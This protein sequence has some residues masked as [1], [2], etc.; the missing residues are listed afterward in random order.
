MNVFGSCP[1]LR[2]DVVQ[3]VTFFLAHVNNGVSP[4]PQMHLREA[5]LNM[6]SQLRASTGERLYMVLSDALQEDQ[7]G[8]EAFEQLEDLLLNTPWAS[9][10]HADE[11]Q[12]VFELL[13][14]MFPPS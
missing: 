5:D 8:L 9:S 4:V 12:K 11:A 1:S 2:S 6:L 14:N 7:D 13:Q 10:P 3:H